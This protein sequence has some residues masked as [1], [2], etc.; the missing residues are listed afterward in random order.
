MSDSELRV[1]ALVE[2]PLAPAWGPGKIAHIRGDTVHVFFRDVPERRAKRMKAPSLQ[3]AGSQSDPILDNLPR[4]V[5]IDGEFFLPAERITLQQARGKFLDSYPGGFHDPAYLGNRKEGE[6]NYKWWAHELWIET[7]GGGQAEEMLARGDIDELATR[8]LR[9][10]G[11]VNLLAMTEA[12]A[13]RE[14]FADRSAAQAYF[15]ALLALLASEPAAA[16]FEPY[17]AAVAPLPARGKTHTNHWPVVT[18]LPYL[19]RPDRWMFVKP[20]NMQRAAERLAIDLRYDP[21]PNWRTYDAVLRM[22]RLYMDLLAD[23]APRDFMD[24]Q[25]FFW[26]TSEQYDEVVA[27]KQ[28]KKHA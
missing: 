11:A 17:V 21:R 24:I 18:I 20:T 1:G 26:V 13:L 9:V 14:G 4:F 19:A 16:S 2:N 25:S 27:T 12:A 8:A 15:E 28:A 7:L 23:L 3:L 5:E 22:S 10:V 6:R